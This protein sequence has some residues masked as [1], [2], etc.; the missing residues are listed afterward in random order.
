MLT[1]DDNNIS[2]SPPL[3]CVIAFLLK[4]LKYSKYSIPLRIV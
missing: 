3:L 1:Y 4:Y 2:K